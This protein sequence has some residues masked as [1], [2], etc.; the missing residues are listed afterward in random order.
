MEHLCSQGQVVSMTLD[1]FGF[2]SWSSYLLP[3]TCYKMGKI[4]TIFRKFQGKQNSKTAYKSPSSVH[5]T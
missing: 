2:K 4:M 1:L 5:V 3:V